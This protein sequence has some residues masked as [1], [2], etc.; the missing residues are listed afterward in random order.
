M[1]FLYT[2]IPVR[3]TQ[4]QEFTTYLARCS[5][6]RSTATHA[7]QHHHPWPDASSLLFHISQSAH[8]L[9][10]VPPLARFQLFIQLEISI[11]SSIQ[12][13]KNELKISASHHC[14]FFLA[15][16]GQHMRYGNCKQMHGVVSLQ[17]LKRAVCSFEHK[18]F[19]DD[20]RGRENKE[21][22]LRAMT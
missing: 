4:R 12:Q 1:Q 8:G 3:L 7:T 13:M 10:L 5:S 21:I 20:K 15:I 17:T 14:Q 16:T 22:G 11:Q 18:R 9:T 6:P 19:C 2:T